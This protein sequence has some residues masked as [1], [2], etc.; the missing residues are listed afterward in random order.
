MSNRF[1]ALTTEQQ[2]FLISYTK[3]S[4]QLNKVIEEL[5]IPGQYSFEQTYN[6]NILL[7]D[8]QKALGVPNKN[9]DNYCSTWPHTKK[10]KPTASD[11]VRAYYFHETL[12]NTDFC[13]MDCNIQNNKLDDILFSCLD[14]EIVCKEMR[15]HL[16]YGYQSRIFIPL[17]ETY[18]Y[19]VLDM[20]VNVLIDNLGTAQKGSQTG[21]N[22]YAQ[23]TVA[24]YYKK[25]YLDTLQH[26]SGEGKLAVY[27][28]I[29]D[30]AGIIH[31]DRNT[32]SLSEAFMAIV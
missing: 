25:H 13:G 12:K 3:H 26:A 23:G 5:S 10:A 24:G 32:I 17:N 1:D 20:I 18:R 4:G 29:L 21:K 22:A 8:V 11:V 30:S 2:D 6:A 14:T 31:N 7:L 27:Y 9:Y 19:E 16:Q 28:G 15:Y